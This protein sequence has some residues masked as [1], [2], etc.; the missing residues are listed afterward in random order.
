MGVLIT[1]VTPATPDGT[2]IIPV[3]KSAAPRSVTTA[4][5][6]AYILDNIEA[7]SAGSAVA[8]DDALYILD[9]TDGA[10][11]PVP[12]DTVVAYALAIMWAKTPET[13]PDTADLVPLLDGSTQKTVTL[14]YLAEL[15]RATIEAAILD[16]SDLSDGS[17]TIST[18]DYLLVT[19]GTTGKRIQISDLS[20]LIYTS[21]KAYVTALGAVTTAGATDVLYCIQGGVE[22]KLTLSQISTYI[23]ASLSGSGTTDYLAQWASSGVLQAG[24]TVVLSTTGFSGAGVDTAVPTTAAVRGEMETIV[25]DATDIGA[26]LEGTDTILVDDG[27]AGT[28]QRK[29]ALSRVW[30]YILS[31]L[32]AVTDVSTYGW[33]VDEDAMGSDLATKVP[34]QQSVKAYA[35][36]LVY[37]GLITTLDIDGALDIGADLADA[38]LLIVDDGASGTNRKSALS[39]VWTYILAKIVAV[40]DVSTYGWVV[41]EDAMGSDLATKVPTQ[42]SVKAYVDSAA[43]VLASVTPGTSAVSKA[44][45]LDSGGD[46]VAG[47]VVLADMVEGSG[48]SLAASLEHSVERAGGLFKT[49]IFIDL[50]G[51]NSG[52]AADD[53]IGDAAAANCHIGQITAAKNGTIVAG[54]VTCLE[55]PVTGDDDIDLYA[56]TEATGTEDTA[57]SGLTSTQLCNSGNLVAG[58][59]VI[60][61][62]L[63]ADTKYL[64]LVAGTGDSDA[65]YSAGILLIELWGK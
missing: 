19:Q 8:T 11:K 15:V 44:L 14:A 65:T 64:Y 46:L 25:Y 51:L 12:I 61:T 34:T 54:R 63:P 31:L 18:T 49:T 1:A 23:G 50:A 62:A 41:D 35:D 48:A 56:A 42:Q 17:G 60:L 32:T 5:L 59:I 39:R 28:A 52:G 26:A 47:P 2:E 29:S 10:F 13:S 3:S 55:T 22:K 45:V 38:D 36:S 27:A 53:I 40:T 7:I 30:T 37:T 57:I 4:A 9:G 20:T 33:V 6:S 24:P 16:V 58:S 21:L 43:S